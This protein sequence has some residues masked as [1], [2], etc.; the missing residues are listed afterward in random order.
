MK[1]KQTIFILL[2]I[3]MAIQV[4]VADG[5]ETQAQTQSEASSYASGTESAEAGVSV[6]ADDESAQSMSYA[7]SSSDVANSE[8]AAF[9]YGQN[10]ETGAMSISNGVGSI[11]TSFAESIGNIISVFS[12]S[13]ATGQYVGGIGNAETQGTQSAGAG[14]DIFVSQMENNLYTVT[15]TASGQAE[16]NA[17]GNAWTLAYG[18]TIPFENIITQSQPI[19]QP[20][21]VQEERAFYGYT[22]GKCDVQRYKHFWLQL[23]DNN[24]ENDARARYNM[25]LIA[26]RLSNGW[27]DQAITEMEERYNISDRY[28]SDL[29]NGNGVK[30]GNWCTMPSNGNGNG[31]T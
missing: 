26:E 16:G 17:Q 14:V 25:E 4:V 19:I 7:S 11:T 18:G 8:T 20:V 31:H 13:I 27:G 22:F 24:T 28:P 5:D 29:L 9:G 12:Q 1:I 21:P 10:T 6:S 15:V 23:K 2:I 30:N 3:V